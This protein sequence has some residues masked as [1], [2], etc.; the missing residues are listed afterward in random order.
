MDACIMPGVKIGDGA[1]IAAKSVVT[2]DVQPY[3]I[4]GG[5]PS[6]ELKKRFSDDIIA[7]L[8]NV[9]WW[10]WNIEKIFKSH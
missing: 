7:A 6:K 1:I 8:L 10:E 2:K 3:T 9:A 4:V 5:N